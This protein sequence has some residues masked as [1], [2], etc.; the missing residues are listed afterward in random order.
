MGWNEEYIMEIVKR[1]KV[2]FQNRDISAEE[3]RQ[4]M[5]QT[6]IAYDWP[7]KEAVR[8]VELATKS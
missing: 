6:L 4:R 3:F 5:K 2:K 7:E 8:M 1:W